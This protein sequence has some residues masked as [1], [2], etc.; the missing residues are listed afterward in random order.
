MSNGNVVHEHEN[1]QAKRSKCSS[2]RPSTV[3]HQDDTKSKRHKSDSSTVADL[4]HDDTSPMTNNAS[5]GI[6]PPENNGNCYDVSQ[7]NSDFMNDMVIAEALTK[8]GG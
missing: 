2:K 8:L 4:R 7:A 1:N 5:V 6:T 3:L